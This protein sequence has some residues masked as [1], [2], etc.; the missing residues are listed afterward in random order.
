MERE[1]E[2]QV[3]NPTARMELMAIFR[4]LANL[5]ETAGGRAL[6]EAVERMTPEER[7]RLKSPKFRAET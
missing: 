3:T 2:T 4:T 5:R 1:L 7:D 6:L